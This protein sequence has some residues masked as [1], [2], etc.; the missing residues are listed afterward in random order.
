MKIRGRKRTVSGILTSVAF[1][2]FFLLSKNTMG[3][4]Q[5]APEKVRV[6]FYNVSGYQERAEN[7]NPRGYGYDYLEEIAKYTGWEYEFIDASWDECLAMLASGE[8]DLVTCANVSP[9]RQELYEY[10]PYRMGISYSVLTV[11]ADNEEY[12]YN[13]FQNFNGMRVGLMKGNYDNLE[14]ELICERNDISMQ[15]VMYDTEAQLK[16]ALYAGDVDAIVASNQRNLE[17]EKVIG[18]FNPEPFYAITGK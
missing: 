13:D 8:I 1:I 11:R 17:N 7:G 16:E 12:C 18:A 15:Q 10:S 2:I 5:A 4:V 14:L 9:E 3:E 6:G